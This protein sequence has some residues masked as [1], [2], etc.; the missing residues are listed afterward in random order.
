MDEK[1]DKFI[2]LTE[3]DVIEAIKSLDATKQ[4]IFKIL[5]NE[6]VNEDI[7]TELLGHLIKIDEGLIKKVG[8][9][10]PLEVKTYNKMVSIKSELTRNTK[11]LKKLSRREKDRQ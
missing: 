4:E 9:Q 2:T 1:E 5:A 6:G 3:T 11:E 8:Y 10:R 7:K